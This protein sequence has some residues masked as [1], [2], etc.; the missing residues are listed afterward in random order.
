MNMKGGHTALE[1]RYGILSGAQ[2]TDTKCLERK[3]IV[4]LWAHV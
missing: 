3:N 1:Y 2:N 4:I